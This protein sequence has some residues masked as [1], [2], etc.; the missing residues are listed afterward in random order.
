MAHGVDVSLILRNNHGDVPLVLGLQ[1][2]EGLAV[3][4]SC[5]LETEFPLPQG[6]VFLR[7]LGPEKIDIAKKFLVVSQQVS[8][9]SFRAGERGFLVG[10]DGY[11][12]AVFRLQSDRFDVTLCGE[13]PEPRV[14]IWKRML[15]RDLHFPPANS[16]TS[17][18]TG[19]RRLFFWR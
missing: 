18:A 4:T 13:T 11:G 1:L 2:S 19:R 7:Q 5:F 12:S 3:V 10:I 15:A 6:E 16:R 14:V 17:I 9:L 8:E